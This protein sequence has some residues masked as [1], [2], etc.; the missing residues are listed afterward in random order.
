MEV[1][2]SIPAAQFGISPLLTEVRTFFEEK[3]HT[4]VIFETLGIF[5]GLGT[6]YSGILTCTS[7]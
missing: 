2:F 7:D 1:S 3:L 4:R 6:S 5:T